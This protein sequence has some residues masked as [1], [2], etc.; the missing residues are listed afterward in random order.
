MKYL[1]IRAKGCII[2]E[3]AVA[4]T[5]VY[6][7]VHKPATNGTI[8]PA[9]NRTKNDKQIHTNARTHIAQRITNTSG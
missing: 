6:S 8:E 3:D 7:C 4:T 2:E 9:K 1:T 5:S